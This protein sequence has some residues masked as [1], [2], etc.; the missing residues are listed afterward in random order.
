MQISQGAVSTQSVKCLF[1]KHKDLSS[2]ASKLYEKQTWQHM[3][4][5]PVLWRRKQEDPWSSLVK[6]IH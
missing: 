1:Y 4:V 6:Q 5:T 2:F 3:P